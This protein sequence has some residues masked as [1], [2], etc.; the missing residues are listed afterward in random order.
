MDCNKQYEVQYLGDLPIDNLD[1]IA[2]FFIAE[3]DVLDQSTGNTLT[4]L[5][6]VPG[7]KLFPNANMDNITTL[8][9][10]NPDITVPENQVRAVYVA[11]ETTGAVMHYADAEHPADMIAVGMLA[12][13]ILV[14]ESGFINIPEGHG[15]IFGAQYYVGNNGEPVTDSTITGQ[16]LF[17]PISTTK[18]LINMWG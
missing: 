4:T 17:K 18:L 12:D 6:R 2:D 15:L 9:P 14:Q 7:K 3:R 8:T 10:N 11:N 5:V 1:D 13:Y 16:K